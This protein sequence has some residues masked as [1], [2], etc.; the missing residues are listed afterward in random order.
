MSRPKRSPKKRHSG[1][2]SRVRVVED[3]LPPPDAL[4][5]KT[6]WKAAARKPLP[7]GDDPDDAMEEIEQVTTEMP[8]PPRRKT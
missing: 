4:V 3:F 2:I 7:S 8:K 5:P 1:E 6:D